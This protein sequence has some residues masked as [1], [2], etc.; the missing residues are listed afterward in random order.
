MTSTVTISHPRRLT[1]LLAAL[2]ALGPFC[3]DTY[4]PAFPAMAVSLNAS[5]VAIQQTLTAYLIPFAFMM[6][7][8]GA[9]SDSLGRRRV[10]LVGLA[11]FVVSTLICAFATSIEMLLVG[12]A[13]QGLTAG[14]GSVVGRAMVRD[15]YSG[16]Q[17]QRALASIA[18]L[19]G[20]APAIAP[21]V[22][23]F[24]LL[25]AG[26][27]AI[28]ICLVVF[29]CV[30]F[31]ACWAWLPETLPVAQRQSMHPINLAK[32][33]AIV[34]KH[35]EFRRLAL[36]TAFN[37]SGMFVYVLAAPVFLIRHLG[38][39]AQGFGIMFMPVVAGMMLGSFASGRL[40]GRL[41]PVRTI[42]LGYALMT[43]AA[44]VNVGMNMLIPPTLPWA[45]APM[46]LFAGGMALAMPNLQLRALDFFPERRGLASSC[47]GVFLTAMN[48]L[49]AAVIVP[50]LWGSTLHLALGMAAFL[51]LGGI[52]FAL[53]RRSAWATDRDGLHE[54]APQETR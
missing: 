2:S 37:F 10:I 30:L 54:S 11:L 25:F 22:G 45:I 32:G 44:V 8:H 1:F 35:H 20:I 33:Y 40:A 12:R 53:S 34:F 9:L 14:G 4:L 46:V 41:S 28:F 26:W 19:F 38:L 21:L 50:L 47:I 13:L 16:V 27:Q 24:I 17:A 48:A 31:A 23:G 52:T 5:D 49:A 43:V 36:A 29:S 15:V 6:L 39:S 42:S 7:W 51:A 18:V 3:I